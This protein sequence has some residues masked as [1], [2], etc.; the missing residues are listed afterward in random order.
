MIDRREW[1]LIVLA[2][3]GRIFYHHQNTTSFSPA[4]T[5]NPA[6]KINFI[7]NFLLFI[8][9]ETI[10]TLSMIYSQV[11]HHDQKFEALGRGI[12]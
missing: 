10:I 2:I 12:H 5:C 7:F 11:N 8:I 4:W 6:I 1:R 9:I 3:I